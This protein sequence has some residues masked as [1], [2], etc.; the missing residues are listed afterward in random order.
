M[1]DTR[2]W[3][4]VKINIIGIWTRNIET[5]VSGSIDFVDILG[6][7]LDRLVKSQYLATSASVAKRLSVKV[8]KCVQHV[9]ECC[10]SEA[11]FSSKRTKPRQ[12]TV[13][14]TIPGVSEG[15]NRSRIVLYEGRPDEILSLWCSNSIQQ[16]KCQRSNR[17]VMR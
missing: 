16:K 14:L 3:L 6:A 1:H 4:I 2:G 17:M 10:K 11:F 8:L 9:H 15:L 7:K 5:L 13:R 12:A